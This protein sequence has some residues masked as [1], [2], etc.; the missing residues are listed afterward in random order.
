M[1]LCLS[2]L[3]LGKFEV[4]CVPDDKSHHACWRD[5]S[6]EIVAEL[7]DGSVY[8][9]PVC[10]NPQH[11][12]LAE[13]AKKKLQKGVRLAEL[14]K[15][16]MKPQVFVKPSEMESTKVKV[17]AW[18]IF[19]LRK[20]TLPK[21]EPKQA[22]Q[23]Q[24]PKQ[25]TQVKQLQITQPVQEPT[26]IHTPCK[27]WTW[28]DDIGLWMNFEGDIIPMSKLSDKELKHTA[29]AIRDTNFQNLTAKTK[30][31]K[32]LFFDGD[33]ESFKF[34]EEALKVGAKVAAEKL[35]DFRIECKRRG[36]I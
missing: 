5:A 27:K 17:I 1:E 36:Y 12:H 7:K 23:P 31:T 4:C 29:I 13:E 24:Q 20:L 33:T 22:K 10:N 15:Y 2:P 34:P 25:V 8:Y 30:W 9:L 18:E 6:E 11:R 28:T 16:V 35:E 26:V 14:T 19:V 32:S 21:I 3:T